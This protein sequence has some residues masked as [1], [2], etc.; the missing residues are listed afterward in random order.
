MVNGTSGTA[1]G[2]VPTIFLHGTIAYANLAAGFYFC[3]GILLI[4]DSLWGD[5]EKPKGISILGGILIT[6]GAWTRPE[7]LTIN[8]VIIVLI[9]IIGLISWRKK[10]RK[11]K[12]IWV[13]LPMIVYG[14]LWNVTS[15]NVYVNMNSGDTAVLF[16]GLK[17]ILSGN[18]NLN[19][20]LY[21]VNF[22]FKSLFDI[23]IWGFLGWT[24][25]LSILLLIVR[26]RT[27]KVVLSSLQFGMI[28]IFFVIG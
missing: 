13:I 8:M 3:A 20:G 17:E 12:V 25:G 9:G 14:I 28:Y 4:T 18:F 24:F 23:N 7:T 11:T 27:R 26:G 22:F 10:E 19:E 2:T 21:L 6:L 5:T 16:A 1:R 15:Q